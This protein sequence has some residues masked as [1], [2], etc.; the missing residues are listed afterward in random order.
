VRQLGAQEA[1]SLSQGDATLQ[2]K[3]ANLIDDA[4]ALTN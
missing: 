2:Q 1:L 3:G 4:S